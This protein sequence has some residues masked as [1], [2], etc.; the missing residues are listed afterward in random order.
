LS[1]HPQEPFR[2]AA[3]TPVLH[4]A[5][6]QLVGAGRW[7]PRESLGS[8][9][10]RFP[11][12]DDPGDTGWHVDASFAP[13]PPVDDYL[14]WRINLRSK[15]RA[16]LLLFLFSDVGEVDAPTRIRIGSHAPVARL[17]AQAGEQGMSAIELAS[18]AVPATE[19]MKE[20]LATGD[21]GT[22][23][24]CHPFLL[25]SAQPHRGQMPRFIAQP[26]LCPHAPLELSRAHGNYS[27]VEQAVRLAIKLK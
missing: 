24:L 23:F 10:I 8:F 20:T 18:K 21:A 3:N 5:F 11:H 25:H 14:Q 17:L 22:V 16:L 6:D 13:D 2:Q 9:P 7:I 12:P 1:D 27:P 4:R 26:P 15:G 19:G